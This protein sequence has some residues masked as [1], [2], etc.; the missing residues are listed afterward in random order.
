[1]VKTY[2][3]NPSICRLHHYV[4]YTMIKGGRILFVSPRNSGRRKSLIS[5][6]SQAEGANTVTAKTVKSISL[7]QINGIITSSLRNFSGVLHDL[8]SKMPT[9]FSFPF[10]F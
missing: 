7:S 6:S 9:G 8:L 2:T 10:H 3:F 1:M 4:H 5:S